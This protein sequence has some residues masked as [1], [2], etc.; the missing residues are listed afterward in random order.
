M[1]TTFISPE[2]EVA[3]GHVRKLIL[4]AI[5]KWE[6]VDQGIARLNI[7]KPGDNAPWDPAMAIQA[8]LWEVSPQ[9]AAEGVPLNPNGGRFRIG[10]SAALFIKWRKRVVPVYGRFDP[11]HPT[12]PNHLTPF[13][14]LQRIRD[15][16]ANSLI[17]LG[18]EAILCQHLLEGKR[19]TGVKV[20]RWVFDGQPIQTDWVTEYA[21]EHNVRFDSEFLIPVKVIDGIPGLIKIRIGSE[22]FYGL[23]AFEPETGGIEIILIYY[24]ELGDNDFPADGEKVPEF[25][26]ETGAPT[27]RRVWR[28]SAPVP[29]FL[30]DKALKVQNFTAEAIVNGWEIA[31]GIQIDWTGM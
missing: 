20:G 10:I 1:A 26:A 23:V 13:A 6:E 31:P 4:P 14:G 17:E 27:G 7:N 22:V 19:I 8:K 2:G 3:L 29:M 5:G 15:L 16:R 18:E 30:T 9:D 21:N 12:R 24:A 11:T 25:D 28:E